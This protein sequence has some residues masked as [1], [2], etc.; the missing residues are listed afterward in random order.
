MELRF[1]LS[2]NE[3]VSVAFTTFPSF[4]ML[5]FSNR[6]SSLPSWLFFETSKAPQH[7]MTYIAETDSLRIKI[8]F[9]QISGTVSDSTYTISSIRADVLVGFK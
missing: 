7:K 2:S 5:F 9:T 3:M 6:A 8:Y 4:N 1:L